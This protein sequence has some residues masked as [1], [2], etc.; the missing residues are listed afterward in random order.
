MLSPSLLY[1]DVRDF[2]D[3]EIQGVRLHVEIK[4]KCFF[5]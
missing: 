5:F 3:I 1:L 2:D 4:L